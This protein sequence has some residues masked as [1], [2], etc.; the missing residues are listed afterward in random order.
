[1]ISEKEK[2]KKLKE[3]EKAKKLREKEKAKKL[4]EKEKA[5]KLKEKEKAKKQREKEKAKKLKQKTKKAFKSRK[6]SG[7]NYSKIIPVDKFITD[8]LEKLNLI[9]S[10]LN[11]NNNVNN[12]IKK[13]TDAIIE[14]KTVNLLKN[15]MK[16]HT[17]NASSSSIITKIP[18]SEIIS[19]IFKDVLKICIVGEYYKNNNKLDVENFSKQYTVIKYPTYATS[20]KIYELAKQTFES[21]YPS[22]TTFENITDLPEVTDQ[23]FKENNVKI[24]QNFYYFYEEQIRIINNNQKGTGWFKLPSLSNLRK[25]QSSLQQTTQSTY[26]T[27]GVLRV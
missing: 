23:F 5:K 2:A 27:P 24:L 6:V 4:R 11:N 20:T 16:L 17:D 13:L 9:E 7:G 8:L 12:Y 25:N 18:P 15:N 1:M 10:Q 14:M 22:I 19:D 26:E 3:K 21:L